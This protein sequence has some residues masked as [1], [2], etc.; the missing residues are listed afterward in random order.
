MFFGPLLLTCKI[1][2]C[3]VKV[4]CLSN[5]NA[6]GK[7]NVRRSELIE[8]VKK[9]GITEDNIIIIDHDSLQDGFN[10]AWDVI[11]VQ[12]IVTKYGNYLFT[13]IETSMLLHCSILICR[14]DA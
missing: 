8:S 13:I 7:G 11:V 5:G 9:F 14:L 2:E 12:D 4:L 1:N 10:N 3:D 6:D